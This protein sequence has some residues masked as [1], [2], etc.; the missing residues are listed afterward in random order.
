MGYYVAS[1]DDEDRKGSQQLSREADHL[2]ELLNKVADE[3]EA[4]R[5][6]LYYFHD[7]IDSFESQIAEYDTLISRAQSALVR[8]TGILEECA[9]FPAVSPVVDYSTDLAWIEDTWLCSSSNS[10]VLGEAEMHWLTG[11]PQNALNAVSSI[12]TKNPN[13]DWYDAMK[14]R[15]FMAAILHSSG[16]HDESSYIVDNVLRR[17][18][19]HCVS[20]HVQARELSGV[21]YFIKG[22][23]MMV[24][25]NWKAAY[26]S[27][28]HALHTPGY[29]D[30]AQ[31]YQRE[32]VRNHMREK[33]GRGQRPLL[34]VHPLDVTELPLSQTSRA[35]E[36]CVSLISPGQIYPDQ[37]S[38]RDEPDYLSRPCTKAS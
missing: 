30:K 17:C 3:R 7:L 38:T 15:L 9:Y 29:Q 36:D 1:P 35:N 2:L 4:V 16:V 5:R 34:Q 6:N 22:K 37:E 31:K 10:A 23:D 20:D 8:I 18:E 11:H 19:E 14:C 13:I 21:S 33:F 24:Q 25:Q 32:A 26:Q 27:F 12:L 28:A